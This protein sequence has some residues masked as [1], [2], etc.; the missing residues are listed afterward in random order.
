M[1]NVSPPAST[2]RAFPSAGVI[3]PTLA[4]FMLQVVPWPVDQIGYVNLHYSITSPRD[5]TAKNIVTGKPYQSLDKYVGFVQWAL[6]TTSIKDMWFCTSLQAHAGKNSKGGAKAMRMAGSALS[7]KAVWIDI[8]VRPEDT[9]GQHYTSMDEAHAAFD[10]FRI[11]ARLPE[12]SAVIHTGGGLHIYWI[13]DALLT[14]AEWKPYAHGLKALMI[15]EELKADYGLTTD[16]CRLL[17]VPGTF[18]HKYDPPR[19]VELLPVPLKLYSFAND[20]HFLTTH[21]PAVVTS[22]AAVDY[23]GNFTL[24]P[25][26]KGVLSPSLAEGLRDNTPIPALPVMRGCKFLGGAFT[27]GGKSYD[28]PQWLLTTLAATFFEDGETY[29]HSM[30]DRHPGYTPEST[31]ALYERKLMDRSQR[32]LGYPS[33]ATIEGTGFAGCVTCPLKG[34][35]KSPLNIKPE[36]T[37]T[38]TKGGV[39]SD[40]LDGSPQAIGLAKSAVEFRDINQRGR[41]IPSL[42]NAAIAIRALG[43][44]VSYDMFHNRTSVKY[45]G[46]S[47]TIQDGFLTD[48]TVGAVRSLVNNAFC[49]D[50]GD[51]NTLAALREIARDNAFDPV[52][53][54]LDTCQTKWDGVGRLDDWVI[55]YLGCVDTP[56]NRAIGRSVLLAAC[57]RA[58]VPGCKFDFITV[59]EG[60][61]GINKSTVIRV[62]AG[63]D[64]FNDQSI[65]GA[66]DKEIQ[67]QLE[68]TWMHENA[69]LAGMRR[70]DVEQVKAF[71]SRQVD[72][73]RPAYGRVRED[74]PRRSIEWAT[75]NNDTYLLSQTGNRRWWT[76]KTGKIDIEALR[77]DREQLLGEAAVLEAAGESIGLDKNLWGDARHAQELRRVADPWED[78]LDTMPDFII[79]RSND[80]NE[81]VAT[82]DVLTHAL[83]IPKAQQTSAHGQRLARVMEH[84]GNW[85]RNGSGRVTIGGVAVRGYIRATKVS[86]SGQ[87]QDSAAPQVPFDA[88]RRITNAALR[89]DETEPAPQIHTGICEA[90]GLTP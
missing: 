56:L 13:N 72:R 62:L 53:E 89:Y 18:N 43:I 61:E 70:A 20:L 71:A 64:N 81:R 84:V 35:V 66:S 59:L 38:V 12:P 17:R 87:N 60:P 36:I 23:G 22:K 2:P 90:A 68:G 29:A 16:N 50:C 52:L 3:A 27:T 73:A 58:R 37:A 42:A 14:A 82:S 75:T 4:E 11:K 25:A 9:S 67:E 6:T 47:K 74:R 63:D 49:I 55:R 31:K 69:D 1:S 83:Q 76:L 41:P 48:H 57:R 54:L 86:F 8:D 24:H 15:R 33:C 77:H 19:P 51:A 46:Q 10:A 32:D 79:C 88:A 80:G 78:L 30:A 65:L 5:H 28:N 44:E 39:A 85:Q 40:R 34:R 45:N 7:L 21:A 26:F